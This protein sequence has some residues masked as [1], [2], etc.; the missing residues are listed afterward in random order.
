MVIVRNPL[1][2]TLALLYQNDIQYH[3]VHQFLI[4]QMLNLEQNRK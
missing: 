3:L 1:A 4:D 2:R